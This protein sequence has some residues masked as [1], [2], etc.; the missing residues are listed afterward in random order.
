MIAAGASVDR[1]L[2]T[3]YL[4]ASAAAVQYVRVRAS[5][6]L[7]DIGFW[8]AD[9]QGLRLEP[10]AARL[11]VVPAAS[12]AF[13][14]LIAEAR[15]AGAASVTPDGEYAA[16]GD[17]PG[18]AEIARAA[19]ELGAHAAMVGSSQAMLDYVAASYPSVLRGE[20]SGL[21]IL[22]KGDGLALWERYFSASNPLYDV[23]NQLLEDGLRGI[24]PRA[25]WC[26]RILELGTGT[27]GATAVLVRAL[28]QLP[29]GG[30]AEV[31]LSDISPSWLVKA[32]ER[33]R[34]SCRTIRTMRIDFGRALDEQGI[35]AGSIDV[36]I[37]VNALHASP[38]LAGTLAALRRAMAPGGVLIVSESLCPAGGSV[39]QEF[40]FNLL[41]RSPGAGAGS[42][43]FASAHWQQMLR[44][45]GWTARALT[46][47]RG[48]ELAMLAVASPSAGAAATSD[49]ATA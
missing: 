15:A 43:F 4:A 3:A 28:E 1:R 33:F 25:G 24:W 10:L 19:R 29:G 37:A 23:H 27:G 18:D 16:L 17:R 8:H 44:R 31:I 22:L 30:E 32:A 13:S 45:A 34:T 9:A 39:H 46:N 40:V 36:A 20:R 21:S 6:V 11:G 14:W 35:A 48:P 41:G 12:A 38:D 5:R 42:R 2:D 49:P 47:G 26:P 7:A